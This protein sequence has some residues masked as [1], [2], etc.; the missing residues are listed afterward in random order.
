LARKQLHI[1]FGPINRLIA[2]ILAAGDS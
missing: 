1:D 2:A